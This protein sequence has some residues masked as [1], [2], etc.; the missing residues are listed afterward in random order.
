MSPYHRGEREVQARAEERER[1]DRAARTIRD[2]I[3]EVIAAFL[4]MQRMAVVGACDPEGRMWA[5]LLT[6]PPGLARATGPHT[7][8]LARHW[9]AGDPL[10]RTFAAGPFPVGTLFAD[11]RNRLR[12]RINGMA[13]PTARGFAVDADQVF[14]NCPG[15]LRKRESPAPP[16]GAP[17]QGGG[18]GA[19][20]SPAQQAWIAGADTFFI[21][22]AS[23]TGAADASHRGGEPGFVRVMSPTELSWPDYQGN[24][25]FMTLGNLALNPGAGLLFLDWAHGRTL[26]LTGTARTEFTGTDRT[27]RFTLTEAVES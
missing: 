6:G 14:T 13:R 21:S 11:V 24:A 15:Q 23:D 7:L 27:V 17:R 22:S 10:A 25:M 5:S 12:L 18:S 9:K 26:Q 4:G 19:A 1:A 16:P 3:S 2:G 8:S 20:L